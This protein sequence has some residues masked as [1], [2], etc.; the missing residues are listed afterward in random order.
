MPTSSSR[1]RWRSLVWVAIVIGL[2]V[3]GLV[4]LLRPA[5]QAVTQVGPQLA[6]VSV[7]PDAASSQTV[8][9]TSVPESS[10]R[11]SQSTTATP[12]S[13]VAA[14]PAP[15]STATIQTTSAI[16]TVPTSQLKPA[17]PPTVT[18]TVGA[19][20]EKPGIPATIHIPFSTSN[21]QGGTD[22]KVFPH[23]IDPTTGDM[24]IP[25]PNE[26]LGNWANDVSWLNSPGYA[27]G[28]STR[29]AM[30]IAGHINDDHI[31]GALSDLAEYYTN[32][33][34]QT[35]TVTM[36]DGRVRTYQVVDGKQINKTA[37]AAEANNGPLHTYMFG[38]GGHGGTTTNPTEQLRFIS[39]GG[40]YDPT[41]KNYLYNIVVIAD[42]VN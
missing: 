9:S 2:L 13:V 38:Q 32:H 11:S 18:V 7:P 6:T 5:A 16:K 35:F 17:A 36:T 1:A 37:L 21:H 33:K 24:W 34:G 12:S 28:F 4:L 22:M 25:G 20:V 26:G 31:V 15:T 23:G 14:A 10:S 41:T 8:A 29:G 39:C 3:G 27:G 19:P 40:D 42:P 30:I